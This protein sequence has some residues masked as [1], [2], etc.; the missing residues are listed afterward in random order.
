MVQ[1]ASEKKPG[2]LVQVGD[3]SAGNSWTHKIYKPI[4]GAD[5]MTI[6]H[7]TSTSCKPSVHAKAKK[8][9][10]GIAADA[11]NKTFPLNLKKS[12]GFSDEQG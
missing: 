2:P 9:S 10:A 4:E 7:I 8:H 12:R 1:R 6:Y 5:L 11:A 3:Q